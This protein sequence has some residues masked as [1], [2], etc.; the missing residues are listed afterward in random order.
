MK[1]TIKE[2]IKEAAFVTAALMAAVGIACIS[3]K[4]GHVF[5]DDFAEQVEKWNQ[6]WVSEHGTEQCFKK[7]YQDYIMPLIRDYFGIETE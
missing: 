7:E 4:E 5:S 1:N 2:N 6:E 3:A